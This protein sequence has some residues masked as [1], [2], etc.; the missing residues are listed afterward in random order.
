MSPSQ[1]GIT[2]RMTCPGQVGLANSA[3][4]LG[5]LDPEVTGL[6]RL[7]VEAQI[8]PLVDDLAADARRPIEVDEHELGAGIGV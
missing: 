1:L 2:A 5:L 4:A 3:A 6:F 7:D 8:A